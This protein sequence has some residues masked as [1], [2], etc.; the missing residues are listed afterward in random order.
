MG[1]GLLKFLV[2]SRKKRILFV[3]VTLVLVVIL[4]GIIIIQSQ[5]FESY[6][7]RRADRY[8]QSRY[9]LSLEAESIDLSLM[10]LAVSLDLVRLEP[11]SK[12]ASPLQSFSAK[13]LFLNISF[14]T[15]FSSLFSPKVHI[16]QLQVSEP[17]I[18]INPSRQQPSSLPLKT[19]SGKKPVEIR[20]DDFQLDKGIFNYNNRAYPFQA[21]IS[22]I[23]ANI[24]YM[25]NEKTH[26][27]YILSQQ[28]QLESSP[29]KIGL[30]NL[31][32]EFQ[33]DNDSIDISQLSI[34]SEL[35]N[36]KASAWIQDYQT[37]PQY[38]LKMQSVLQLDQ[39]PTLINLDQDF[40]GNLEVSGSIEG[41][42]EKLN[43]KGRISGEKT[44][45]Y[46]IPFERF[47]AVLNG[48]KN[49][50]SISDL[51]LSLAEGHL[52]AS[53]KMDLTRQEVSSLSLEW[54]SLDLAN[55]G[56]Y[57]PKL[58]RLLSSKT[59]GQI[60]AR[61]QTLNLNSI[62]AEGDITFDSSS[63]SKSVHGKR[64]YLDG[65]IKFSASRGQMEIY[66]SYLSFDQ[67]HLSFN[68]RLDK[69][70]N[71]DGAFS[72][73]S[74]DLSEVEN[75]ILEIKEENN[76]PQMHDLPA[77]NLAG[78]ISL[79]GSVLGT[80]KE[81]KLTV[82]ADGKEIAIGKIQMRSLKG[83]LT[84][85]KKRINLNHLDLVSTQGQ[86]DGQG[87]AS[88]DPQ[89]L[90]FGE[91]LE[92]KLAATDLDLAS[93]S[94][95]SP[96][97][98]PVQG[99]LSGE[100]R[101]EGGRYDP[102]VRWAATITNLMIDR[103][104]F[105]RVEIE[106]EYSQQYIHLTKLGA[107][108]GNGSLE[109]T[110]GLNLASKSY[111]VNI[112]GRSFELADIKYLPP[113]YFAGKINLHLEGQGT[114]QKPEFLFW[115][116]V[117]ELRAHNSD[118]EYIKLEAESDGM[119]ITSRLSTPA[120]QTSLQ[121]RLLL[122]EP[123][124]VQGNFTTSELD[125]FRV[126][127]GR[128]TDL[129][130]QLTSK[131]TAS[132]VFSVPLK[133]WLGSNAQLSI[134]KASFN[135]GDISI[136]NREPLKLQ[137][138]N[139][140]IQ[141]LNFQIFGPET[142]IDLSGRL[143]LR[144]KE[145][146]RIQANGTIELKLIEPFIAQSRASGSFTFQ[147]EISGNLTHPRLQARLHLKEGE[148]NS[149][150]L[151]YSLH[152]CGFLAKIEEN[153]LDLEKLSFGLD[154]ANLSAHGKMSLA[155]LLRKF[156]PE[157]S[158]AEL[159]ENNDIQ[160]TLTGLNLSPLA[161]LMPGEIPAE[162]GGILEGHLRLRGNYTALETMKIEGKISRFAVFLSQF[163]IEN[164]ED[165][166]FSLEEGTFRLE[167]FRLSGENSFLRAGGEIDLAEE[168]KMDAWLSA[169]LDSAVLT[170]FFTNIILGGTIALNLKFTGSATDPAIQGDGKIENGF[171]QSLDFPVILTNIQGIIQFS[172]SSVT[173]T[174]IEGI[175][176]GGPFNIK[177][178]LTYHA[179]T[180]DSG[181][182]EM[183]VNRVQVNYPEGMQAQANA[184][185]LLEDKASGWLL[186]GDVNVI[187][188]YYGMNIYLGSEF[189][190]RIRFWKARPKSELPPLVRNLNLDIGI[191][192][193]DAIIIDNNLAQLE[194]NGNI[195]VT[196]N[197]AEILLSGFVSN[198][199]VGE[200]VFSDRR[201]EVEQA[202][203]EFLGTEPLEGRLN[204]VAHTR[205]TH[206][207]D[208]LDVT[209]T[210]MGPIT[211]LSYSLSSSPPRSQIELSSLLIT[212]YGIEKLK[213]NTANI[214]GNQMIQYF[215]SPLASPVAK[216]IKN[217]LRAEE[218]TIEPINIATEEDPGARFTFRKGLI[219][220]ADIVYSVDVSN[221]QQQ[222]WL[223]DYNLNRNFSIQ[224]FRKDDGSY[225]SSISH[226]FFLGSQMFKSRSPLGE[227]A[228]GPVVKDVKLEGNLIFPLTILKKNVRALKK[229][230]P[231]KY[232]YLLNSIQKLE[233][234]YK[235]N[236]HLNVVINP[237]IIYENQ[238]DTIISLNISPH[239]PVSILYEKDPLS[240]NIK[241]EV[242]SSWN[243]RLP[244]DMALAEAKS[245]ILKALRSKGYYEA[246]VEA[247]K[248]SH[249]EKSKYTFVVEHGP[250]YRIREF[251]LSGRSSI[252][253]N[254]I[255]RELTKIPGTK[256][257][258]LWI[259]LYD[260]K[261]AKQRIK[262]LYMENGYLSPEIGSPQARVNRESR[263]IL[264]TLPVEE[265]PQSLVRFVELRNN[266]TFED[267]D[268]RGGLQLTEK[269]VYRPTLLA[270]DHNFL[271]N[272]YKIRGY[273]EVKITLEI[274]PATE[275]SDIQLIYNIEEGQLHSIGEILISG[276]KRTPDS[277]IRR[278]LIFSEGDPVNME[279]MILSQKKLY[280]L[281]IFRVVN[282][283]RE[284]IEGEKKQERILV[285]VH[286]D[287]MLAL[288]YGVRY[289]S[290]EKFEGFGEL[291]IINILGRGRN[292][293]L[294]Y[295]QNKRQKDFRFSLK[296]PYL[297]GKR[298][299]TLHSL[300]YQEEVSGTFKTKKIGYSIQQEVRL[301]FDFS[302]SYLYRLN[303]IHTF[304]LNPVGPFIFDIT[305]L[306]SELETFL[307]RDTRLNKLNAHQGSFFSLSITYSPKFLGSDFKYISLFCQYSLYK[308]LSSRVIW[309]SNYRIGLADAFDQVL[310]PSKRF[311][312]GGGN[313]IRG[314]KRDTV[315]PYDPLLQRPEGG[316]ALFIINQEIRFPI[317]KWLEGV[318][319][320]DVG[321]VYKYLENFNPFE[322]RQ[323]MGLGLRFNTP[324]VLIRIDYG[325][326]LSPRLDEPKGIFFISLGQA[327]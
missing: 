155:S 33:F 273:Q 262:D 184:T 216:K 258:G 245:R 271:L 202:K 81:P 52:R 306:L 142:T 269:A 250:R 259:L 307:V 205:L 217:I 55:L 60:E 143:P 128:E 195:K 120:W 6:L 68:F 177:G 118:L 63:L 264:I 141:I 229:G 260:F 119:T 248:E 23:T 218:V 241:K 39:V 214:I 284:P 213:T 34:E 78:Q 292:G 3:I 14:R 117:E 98:Y 95:F 9:N 154:E 31:L 148:L 80:L 308:R 236:N 2:G 211:N 59:Q 112:T 194:M 67:T 73:S 238:R 168:S 280:D 57:F 50:L 61:G 295:K 65:K 282:I 182:V 210:L 123:H 138:E 108:R 19:A 79:A 125:I 132:G 305:L 150:V 130:L 212:G 166:Q 187:Q 134:E 137:L 287:P 311:F 7:L 113:D 225:G 105:S 28:S 16:Q 145:N 96:L 94:I 18:V 265:G 228:K 233:A 270:E 263:S 48:N 157:A 170:P 172:E 49:A 140:E 41:G 251:T 253:S 185:L 327:F 164:E 152:D 298:L 276:N 87:Y 302:L 53:M 36:L 274:V 199:Y 235:K 232:G 247:R 122:R 29:Y 88:F 42:L 92:L 114:F 293:I 303:R 288:N 116:S 174:S 8:L 5:P 83:S 129:P 69:S 51:N 244:E 294:Y 252:S 324:A 189:W 76:V 126:V 110:L 45:F 156:F 62:Q 219:K 317:Y 304:E 191:S 159:P 255:K 89:S 190:N 147:G 326:N 70:K 325:I 203:I 149:L 139:Q 220:N 91:T 30:N 101:I 47:E 58:P 56:R 100:A 215:A 279:K 283:S 221:T 131:I 239:K 38:S 66:P 127:P 296:D 231:F 312:A 135:Y 17:H 54:D 26:S 290:E 209:L 268:L 320:Y 158:S 226:R 43:Y 301:P 162:S 243:G 286:E 291:D 86:I 310:I 257:K 21:A 64:H 188:A 321:N 167:E 322:V 169:Q 109:G 176:N 75:L 46:D 165:I 275:G 32:V 13:R 242:I 97:K 197:F 11:V 183:T 181:K 179:Y 84:Y 1:K 25:E 35:L 71:L 240:E 289:N 107:A 206:N 72:L 90:T 254:R 314:F 285:K 85:D 323:S 171:L 104:D 15:L 103:E 192:T 222:T 160:I 256:A 249:I 12:E 299:N 10:R 146:G 227:Q 106:G 151:P 175:A 20:I 121:A 193:V 22:K 163:R 178:I 309:A 230:S 115:I 278:E 237:E 4:T 133:D 27:G 277:F 136:Q 272:Y 180:I 300:Y 318:T 82:E 224:S 161:R 316:E 196:G 124:I 153:E 173:I 204:V 24:Q 74:D 144:E 40:S 44:T 37:I 315:G 207:Y 99:L 319:F 246:E 223:L 93:M 77:L 200:A 186:S 208:D 313:S 266:Q 201:Y 267:R 297:F 281:S 198:R 234:F 111:A 102:S 261:R